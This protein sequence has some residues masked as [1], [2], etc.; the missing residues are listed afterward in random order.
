MR[1]WAHRWS[2]WKGVLP[3][4]APHAGSG[5]LGTI[6]RLE[7]FR[8]AYR[9]SDPMGSKLWAA[10]W[11]SWRQ[12]QKDDPRD[13]TAE[14]WLQWHWFTLARD[15][16]GLEHAKEEALQPE[17]EPAF[18]LLRSEVLEWDRQ[19][20]PEAQEQH[21]H[22]AIAAWR[23]LLGRW[24]EVPWHP[25][26][27]NPRR[28]ARGRELEA[29][30]TA[31]WKE[32]L[33]KGVAW[34]QLRSELRKLRERKRGAR[35]QRQVELERLREHCGVGRARLMESCRSRRSAVR[36]RAHATIDEASATGRELRA[37][38]SAERRAEL[39]LEGRRRPKVTRAERRLEAADRVLVNLPRELHDAW[40]AFG[41]GFPGRTPDVR[42]ERFLEWAETEEGQ[43][44][45]A[46]MTEQ[47]LPSD[48]ELARAEAAYYRE[49]YA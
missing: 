19:Q 47:G 18:M 13:L 5:P 11:K 24:L 44:E 36:A 8:S 35:A 20:S 29:E 3:P 14:Q 4:V 32:Q 27:P 46:A 45:I 43:N 9:G 39:E 25:S 21:Y 22:R 49:A 31:R 7:K 16:R 10:F 48:A 42:A 41:D 15:R 2:M 33:R 23:A 12:D 30:A 6:G 34:N 40:R 37:R 38:Y 17:D 28:R 26:V 1:A